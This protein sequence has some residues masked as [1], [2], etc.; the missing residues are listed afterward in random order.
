MKLIKLSKPGWIKTY[1]TEQELR[2]ELYSYLCLECREGSSEF[3]DLPVYPDSTLDEML[4][5]ACGCEFM[6]EDDEQ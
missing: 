2:A 6:V 5:T 4:S 3:G 1:S